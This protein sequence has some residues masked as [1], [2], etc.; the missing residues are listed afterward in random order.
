LRVVV[1]VCGRGETLD[2]R[3]V[4]GRGVLLEP[5]GRE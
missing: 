5:L 1:A 4:M 3:V 2:E